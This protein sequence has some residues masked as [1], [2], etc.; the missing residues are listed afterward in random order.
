[1]R[2][3]ISLV[4]EQPRLDRAWA[5]YTTAFDELRTLAM[6]RHVMI[7]D[8]FDLVMTDKR[9]EKHLAIDPGTDAVVALATFTNVLESM[10]LIS[11]EYFAARW[12]EFCQQGRVWYLGF[13]AIDEAYRSSGIFEA[14]IAQMWAPIQ[15][16]G[17]VAAL[18]ICAFNAAIGLPKAITRT[19]QDLT[20][21]V[22]ANQ[23]D[24]QTYWVFSL[25]AED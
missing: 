14:V 24:V 11:P 22:V 9:V 1:M 10:P 19:L 21:D 16:A 23:A 6:Q 5:M 4:L 12:P 18:D 2:L 7:R 17:G 20:P 13:F 3:E 25:A 15:A 8:E